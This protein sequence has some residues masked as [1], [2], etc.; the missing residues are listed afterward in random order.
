MI[1]NVSLTFLILK[2]EIKK[3]TI[4]KQEF[5]NMKYPVEECNIKHIERSYLAR[6]IVTLFAAE[7]EKI[8]IKMIKKERKIKERRILKI[9]PSITPNKE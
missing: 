4:S 1:V 8:L 9:F 7:I 2:R 3:K 6:R 5:R